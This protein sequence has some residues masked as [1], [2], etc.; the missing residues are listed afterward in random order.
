MHTRFLP[1]LSTLS[2][3]L[4]LIAGCNEGDPSSPPVNN[5]HPPA[6][7]ITLTCVRLD[8]QGGATTDTVRS[9][10]RDT[11]V[12]KGRPETEGVLDLTAGTT[13]R[14]SVTLFDESADTVEDV[15]HDIE[16]EKEGHVFLFLPFGGVDAT[17]LLISGLDKD[18]KGF[19]VGLHFTIV[20]TPGPAASGL[21]N[22]V[23]RHYDSLNKND[24]QFDTDVNRDFPVSIR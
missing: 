3:V 14:C 16:L 6:T 23:L 1:A 12:V 19:D 22:V 11:S 9:T 5:E 17:R 24:T 8:A 10:V 4:L 18:E 7:T 13:W 15:T 2:L 20:V 21:L